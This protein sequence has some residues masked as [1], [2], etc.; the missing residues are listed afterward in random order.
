MHC[1]THTH[2]TGA[3]PDSL[4]ASRWPSRSHHA[5]LVAPW[6]VRCGVLP[7]RA[8][9]VPRAHLVGPRG[10]PRCVPASVHARRA[11]SPSSTNTTLRLARVHGKRAKGP[12]PRGYGSRASRSTCTPPHTGVIHPCRGTT[13]A[14]HNTLTHTT[15]ECA[16]DVLLLLV[17]LSMHTLVHAVHMHAS[18]LGTLPCTLRMHAYAPVALHAA[19]VVPQHS[20]TLCA[21]LLTTTRCAC[22]CTHTA[23]HAAVPC[24]GVLHSRTG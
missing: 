14:Y 5:T 8:E 13:T 20:A 17:L 3:L 15:H 11:S 7:A 1:V 2:L 18:S 4:S 23:H 9:L 6:L 10:P 16:H 19:V 22:V 21:T 12:A 24:V